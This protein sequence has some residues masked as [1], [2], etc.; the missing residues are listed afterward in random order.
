M[1][2]KARNKENKG[3]PS[4]WIYNHKAYYYRPRKHELER[5]EGKGWFLLGK[6]L[7]SAHSEYARRVDFSGDLFL[8][9]QV[10]ERYTIQVMPLKSSATQRSQ[11]R[12]M[13][14][15]RAALGNNPVQGLQSHHIYQYRDAVATKYKEKTANLDLELLSHIFTKSI[16][17][18]ARQ[19]H[20]MT[21]KQV[22]KFSMTPRDRYVEDEELKAALSL[23]S[24][25]LRHY[26]ALK[27]CTGA[28]KGEL[29]SV[30]ISDITDNGIIIHRSKGGKSSIYKW[31]DALREVVRTIRANQKKVGGMYLF[32][33]RRGQPYIQPDGKT[34][35]FD[36]IWQRFM[37]KVVKS[38]VPRF[39]EHD[40]R[41]KV[42]SDVDL[43]RAKELLGHANSR[44]TERVYRRKI[45][46][47]QPAK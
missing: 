4:R 22:V 45:Q 17:W 38:G 14:R 44:T 26:I 13:K 24:D 32:C 42:A 6:T 40:L 16:E 31:T 25:F 8:M 23:A 7:A 11:T 29:L 41:A 35:G 20:P 39:T 27:L 18:G 12:C 2:P 37:A 43:E 3:L 19:G 21:N 28:R 15:V 10:C 9:D 34:S 1:S 36:S 30:R 47:I 46:E 5:F 33:T